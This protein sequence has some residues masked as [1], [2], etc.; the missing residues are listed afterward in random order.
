MAYSAESDLLTGDMMIS[1][2][3]SKAKFINDAADE[4]DAK[5]GWIYETPIPVADLPRHQALL[6][7]QINNKLASGRLI[8][9]L[10]IAGEQNSLHAYGYRLVRE[11]TEELNLI[12]NGVV[13]LDAPRLDVEVTANDL[14]PAIRN[15]DQESL[16]LGF[17]ET[18]LRGTPWWSRPGKVS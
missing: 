4:I 7:K 12:A 5:I 15:H 9:T 10:D 14:T 18:V 2:R 13:D 17:E 16:L 6:L 11:A 8:L 1:A 3:V